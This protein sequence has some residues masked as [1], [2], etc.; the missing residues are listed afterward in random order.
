MNTAVQPP[1]LLVSNTY[2]RSKSVHFK[3]HSPGT[4]I[5]SVSLFLHGAG[6]NCFEK[7]C[8]YS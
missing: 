8:T 5:I 2:T 3:L 6:D 1:H 4:H 7:L